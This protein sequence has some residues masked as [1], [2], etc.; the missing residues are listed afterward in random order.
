M[1]KWCS[2]FWQVWHLK[3]P[4]K[5][6]TNHIITQSEE[7]VVCADSLLTLCWKRFLWSVCWVGSKIHLNWTGLWTFCW[8]CCYI[9]IL[10]KSRLSCCRFR[11]WMLNRET[12]QA[13]WN[14]RSSLE[15]AE[16]CTE[17][18]VFSMSILVHSSRW[19][20]WD[21]RCA[22]LLAWEK[23][24]LRIVFQTRLQPRQ[25]RAG[26]FLAWAVRNDTWEGLGFFSHKIVLIKSMLEVFFHV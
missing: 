21:V 25:N 24:L 16:S 2:L 5:N 10:S 8:G 11:A 7:G 13:C 20:C 12:G 18:L 1:E 19:G 26:V 22:A 14:A 9:Y 4:N 6:N 23:L 3:P 15:T 17:A